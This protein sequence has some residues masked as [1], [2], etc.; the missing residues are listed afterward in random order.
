MKQQKRVDMV[1][2]NP[3]RDKDDTNWPSPAVAWYA[4]TV[5]LIAYGVAIADRFVLSLLIQPIKLDLG[6]SDTKVSL[7]HGFAF[8][9]F[10]SV[11]GIPI[12]RLADR[13]SRRMIVSS[14]IFVW[15]LMTAACGLVTGYWQL[16][17]ARVGVGVG[18]A[19]L[20]PPAYSMIADLF[21][22]QK[23]SRAFSV[24]TTG[25]YAGAG[26]AFIV[27]GPV[28]QS[29]INTPEITLPIVGTI[30]SWQAAFFVVGLPGVLVAAL[31]F[32]VKEPIRHMQKGAAFSGDA[33]EAVPM[34]QVFVYLWKR[35]RV[36]GAHFL[37]YSFL[38]VVFNA[39]LAWTP[40]FLDRSFGMPVGQS[41]PAIGTIILVF[42][43]SGLIVGGWLA[44]RLVL[45]GYTDGAMRAGV[46][47]GLGCIPFAVLLPLMSSV[48][49]VL[50]LYC[51]VLFFASFGFGSAAAAL[52]Q[53][54]P[55]RLRA[56]V[57]AFYLFILSLI[58]VGLGPT[59]TALITDFVFGYDEAVGLSIAIVAVSSGLISALILWRG[60]GPFRAE[61]K[62]Q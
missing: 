48:T 4:V 12:G 46:V 30:R 36:Y 2:P 51:P 61:V 26:L 1:T 3:N 34:R 60:L 8:V 17:A 19:A 25:A 58:A 45:K 16:F 14:G 6:L 23:L 40:A 35:R 32:T 18:E 56:L 55:N 62:I 7:L 10:F 9:I 20:S 15:S 13:Y 31:M 42:G 38:A 37:G 50:V 22:P 49:W 41:G 53:I 24:Y 21:P 33:D 52:Q 44:D 43:S 39:T 28:I 27:A 59:I 11:M 5:L 29:V 47:A 57:S 54:T